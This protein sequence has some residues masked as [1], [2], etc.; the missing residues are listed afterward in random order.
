[1]QQKDPLN[2]ALV[3]DTDPTRRRFLEE[4]LHEQGYH[5]KETEGIHKAVPLF[6]AEHFSLVVSELESLESEEIQILDL[7]RRLGSEAK[8]VLITHHIG[9]E[10]YIKTRAWGAFD[11]ISNSLGKS[12]LM[13]VIAATRDSTSG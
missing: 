13:E 2:K 3:I 5:V 7:V 8:V 12:A 11:C 6:K 4:I 10:V 1:M 9:P